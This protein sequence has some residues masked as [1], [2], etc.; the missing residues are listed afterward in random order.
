MQN[1]DTV[2]LLTEWGKWSRGGAGGLR[3][4]SPMAVCM[5][6]VEPSGNRIALDIS[7]EK[8]LEVDRAVNDLRR[9]DSVRFDVIFLYFVK[10]FGVREV[11]LRM[12][13]TRTKAAQL[14][15]EALGWLDCRLNYLRA[16]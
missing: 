3:A 15:A 1:V 14:L 2:A 10:N 16:A 8:A 4:G 11:G 12:G 6:L 13:L 5:A 9:Q 7:D